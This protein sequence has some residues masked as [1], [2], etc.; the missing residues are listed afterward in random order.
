VDF[1][2]EADGEEL[3]SG[4]TDGGGTGT[5]IVADRIRQLRAYFYRKR[6]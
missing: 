3:V 4:K 6:G 5:Q 1:H 2:V